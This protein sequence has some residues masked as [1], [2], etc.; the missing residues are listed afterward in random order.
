MGLQTPSAPSVLSRG[1]HSLLVFICL[2]ICQALA[3]PLRRQLYQAPVSMQF[4]AT[5]I[6][7]SFGGC[8]IYGLDPQV[9]HSEWP[10]LQSLLQTLSPY[11]LLWI[12]LFHLLR[13]TEETTLW[14]SFFLS[15]MWSVDC[16]WLIQTFGL[17]ST[18][19]WVH[20]MCVFLWLG[21]LTQDDIF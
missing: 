5:S 18:Y 16:I 1:P 6:L 14:S 9:G 3:Q 20:T 2:C 21:Y 4:L 10:F 12:F 13:R 15:F 19:Q 17:I 7:S 11:P 8:I